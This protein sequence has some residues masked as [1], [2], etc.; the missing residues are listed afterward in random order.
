MHASFLHHRTFCSVRPQQNVYLLF[1]C[2]NRNPKEQF[3]TL[4]FIWRHKYHKLLR[5]PCCQAVVI[6]I[7]FLLHGLVMTSLTFLPANQDNWHK[8]TLCE[9][10]HINIPISNCSRWASR[11]SLNTE[12]FCHRRNSIIVAISCF[13]TK[14]YRLLCSISSIGVRVQ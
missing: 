7:S 9:Y 5:R 14:L 3:A 2:S 12:H 6:V 11:L 13:V 10:L 4:F 1:Y 8:A